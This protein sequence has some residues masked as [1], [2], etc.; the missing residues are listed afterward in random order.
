MHIAEATKLD[1]RSVMVPGARRGAPESTQYQ[2]RAV[3]QHRGAQPSR[4]HYIGWVRE[5]PGGR[6]ESHAAAWTKYDDGAPPERHPQLPDEIH[7]AANGAYMLFYERC[8][9]A[10]AFAAGAAAPLEE[11]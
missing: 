1:L 4:G 2:L 8:D 5:R 3:V 9:F 6:G 10:A 11:P 7:G